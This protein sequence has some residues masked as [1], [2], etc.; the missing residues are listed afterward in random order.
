MQFNFRKYYPSHDENLMKHEGDVEYARE[1]FFKNQNSNLHYLLEK[2]YNWMNKFIHPTD[3]CVIELGS[4]AGFSKYYIDHKILLS[5]Y[6]KYSWIDLV[7]DANNIQ[8]EPN[9]VDVFICSH[10]IHHI[11]NPVIFLE[12]LS[13]Y[14]K[15]NGKIII[16]EIYTSV[17]MKLLLLLMRHEG[18]DDTISIYDKDVVANN[19]NDPWSA[20]CSIPK[21]LFNDLEKFENRVN[22]KV[23]HDNKHE[24][25]LFPLSGGVIAKTYTVQL[26]HCILKII[27]KSD[28][29]LTY[30][31]PELFALGRSTVLQ[32][33]K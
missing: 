31:F 27:H 1:Y 16:Q 13:T 4:G 24:F 33:M 19:P 21:L 25:M 22:Y 32:K 30:L 5:D 3:K 6:K 18:Y 7:I 23:I 15:P 20:N 17:A 9:S 10:M 14:L 8:L 2:R 29:L 28:S 12:N 26:P 11:S